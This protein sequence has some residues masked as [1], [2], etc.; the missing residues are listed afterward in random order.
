YEPELDESLLADWCAFCEG[1]AQFD[2]HHFSTILKGVFLGGLTPE[3]E[4]FLRFFSQTFPAIL[5]TSLARICGDAQEDREVLPWIRSDLHQ[6]VRLLDPEFRAERA[7]I[8]Q[9]LDNDRFTLTDDFSSLSDIAI[10]SPN[11][12][13]IY[14]TEGD[15]VSSCCRGNSKM[16]ALEETLY[17]IATNYAL[18]H[19]IMSPLLEC[20]ID[21]SN[22]F[23]VYL[24]GGA[25]VVAAESIVVYQFSPSV[26]QPT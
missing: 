10:T 22:Y 1:S 13:A 7:N 9:L 15:Y 20:D 6:K 2:V 17:H 8:E 24:R 3:V 5:Y 4:R 11:F 19:A 23:E 21:L 18:A 16:Y 14:V 26:G 12:N 25:Y